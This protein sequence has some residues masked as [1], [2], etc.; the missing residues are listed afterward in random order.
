M[1]D[2]PM[3]L[4]SIFQSSEWPDVCIPCKPRASETPW[5]RGFLVMETGWLPS[6]AERLRGRGHS[7]ALMTLCS[8]REH[9]AKRGHRHGTARRPHTAPESRWTQDP[10]VVM[11]AA[12]PRRAPTPS[13]PS[14]PTAVPLEGSCEAVTHMP[15]NHPRRRNDA[16]LE[17]HSR[18]LLQIRRR[19]G[20]HAQEARRTNHQRRPCT[21]K[22]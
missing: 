13:P 8:H 19:M 1:G 17:V 2:R 14:L 16:Q 9:A 3:P 6:R 10:A 22:H 7:T 18:S 11:P 5:Q 20:H 21:F 12:Q 4:R 15:H